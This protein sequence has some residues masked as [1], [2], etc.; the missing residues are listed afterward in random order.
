M[1][2]PYLVDAS[3][4]CHLYDLASRMCPSHAD[5]PDFPAKLSK[6]WKK[7]KKFTTTTRGQLVWLDLVAQNTN[8]SSSTNWPAM[9]R[10]YQQFLLT[11][12]MSKRRNRMTN[13]D[14]GNFGAKAL[15]ATLSHLLHNMQ[16]KKQPYSPHPMERPLIRLGA[17]VTHVMVYLLLV[18]RHNTE[19]TRSPRL[20][21]CNTWTRKLTCGMGF[22]AR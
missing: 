22:G 5:S 9:V 11:M 12:Y 19:N 4:L 18:C 17:H 3:S 7:S 8:K 14:W 10:H 15:N 2:Q 16:L 21:S 20:V 13:H 6:F 1:L